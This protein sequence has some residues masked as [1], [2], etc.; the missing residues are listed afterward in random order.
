MI[1]VLF[2][3]FESSFAFYFV[4]TVELLPWSSDLSLV[5]VQ[6]LLDCLMLLSVGC[7]SVIVSNEPELTFEG[8]YSITGWY[9]CFHKVCI[10]YFLFLVGS[11]ESISNS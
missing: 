1:W 4:E 6:H 5:Q 2:I 10:R 7:I 9:V 11:L 8:V 3:C